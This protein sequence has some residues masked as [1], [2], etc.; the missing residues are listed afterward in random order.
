MED[1]EFMETLL[2]MDTKTRDEIM[3]KALGG[4][5]RTSK[6]LIDTYYK[7]LGYYIGGWNFNEIDEVL[8][9]LKALGLSARNYHDLPIVK[10]AK[11]KYGVKYINTINSGKASN[12]F[13]Q[14]FVCNALD[15]RF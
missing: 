2:K 14:F 11:A 15:M 4:K 10:Q 8:T 1:K 13:I 9:K 3:F 7:G 6:Y 5:K 12:P